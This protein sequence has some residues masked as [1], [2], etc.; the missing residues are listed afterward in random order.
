[1][2]AAF[3]EMPLALFTTLAPMGAG[4]FI[5]LAVAF[6]T[7]KFDESELKKIDKMTLVALA[8]LIVGFIA[9]VFHLTNPLNGVNIFAG[10]GTSPLSNEVVVGIVV[11]IIALVYCVL[12]VMGKLAEGARKGFAVVVAVAAIVLC[13][14][15]GMAYMM[16]T[17]ASWNTFLVPVQ[18]VGFGL[19]GGATLAGMVISL[20]G[21]ADKL[22]SGTAKTALVV[23]AVVGVVAG[24]GGLAGMVGAVSGMSNAMFAGSDLVSAALPF[25]IVAVVA[26]VAACVLV[27]LVT[28]GK[29]ANVMSIIAVV[30]AFAGILCAR[31]AFYA[32]E[33]SVGLS[34]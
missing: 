14:F 16:E 23:I 8:F 21:A 15:T 3:S 17:I 22:A 26:L 25:I 18:I 7:A 9:S 28:R 27:V 2:E 32:M 24:V 10:L 1:M 30:C 33:L 20:S 6:F 31:L 34:I 5:A 12:A 11:V 13:V 19:I 4:A 29:N